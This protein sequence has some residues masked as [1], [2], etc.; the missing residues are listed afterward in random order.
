MSALEFA[1]AHGIP[2]HEDLV[3]RLSLARRRL[4]GVAHVTPVLTSRQLDDA[5]GAK[6]FLKC[7]N[8]Q[9]MGAFKFRGAWNLISGLPP[10]VRARGV[11]AYSS[12]NHAQAVALAAQLHGVPCAVVMPSTAPATKLAG[13][14]GYGAELVHYDQLGEVRELLAERLARERGRTLVP[15]FDHP[16]IV[17]GQG[18]AAAELLESHGPLD[19]LLAPVGGAGLLSGTGLAAAAGPG[20]TRCRVIGVEPAAGDDAVRSFASGRVESVPEPQTICDGAR[21]QRVSELTLALIRRYASEMVTA[22]D[23]Q[24]VRAMRFVWERMKLVVEPTGALALAALLSGRVSLAGQRVG[25]ILSGG[26]VD[27]AQA[28]GWFAAAGDN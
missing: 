14:R 25:V 18:T 15:P 23:A 13:A 4:A 12:G 19:A 24:V 9:R 8:L 20:R 27:L 21:T 28:A 10:D 5:C 17:A 11:V 22:D 1:T 6:V 16:D 26:N 7:E 2:G 3:E